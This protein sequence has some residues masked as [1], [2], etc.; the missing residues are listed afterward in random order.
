MKT[1][2]LICSLVLLTSCTIYTEKQSEA[3]SQAVYA[4]KDSLN[5]ARF[6]LADQY[7]EQTTRIV[8]PPKAR[9]KIDPVFE[10]LQTPGISKSQE[11]INI[12]N[13][14]PPTLTD[15][16][17][18]MIVPE[19][20]KNDPVVAVNTEEYETL[21]KDQ[22]IRKQLESDYKTLTVHK[23]EVDTE[24]AKQQKYNSQMVIDLN[25]MQKQLVE[26]DLAILKR[27]IVIVVL[28]L[29]MGGATY[30]RI[31]GIL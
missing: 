29:L 7:S 18:I 6:D 1:L 13:P 15:G 3:L 24:L 8:K 21:L 5:N 25:K 31:K 17:R 16:R 27:N 20:F 26:K 11:K 23:K 10:N 14:K 4:T 12:I 9:I 2:M 28:F 19:R 30:L 22:A